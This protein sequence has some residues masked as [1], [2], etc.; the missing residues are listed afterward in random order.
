VVKS[1]PHDSQNWPTRGTPQRGQSPAAGL[2]AGLAETDGAWADGTP[3]AGVKP[4]STA[5]PISAPQ[6]SQ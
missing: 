3:A 4:V 1:K 6:T 2:A 5:V